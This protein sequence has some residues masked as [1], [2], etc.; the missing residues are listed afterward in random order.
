MFNTSTSQSKRVAAQAKAHFDANMFAT[1]IPRNVK[2][3]EAPKGGKTIFEHAPESTGA[4]AYIA[5]V[6]EVLAL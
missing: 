6:D 5:F 1:K 2:L 4:G 3:F